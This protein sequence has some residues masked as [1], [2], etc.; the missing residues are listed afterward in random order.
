LPILANP[1]PF[2]LEF[3]RKQKA[4]SVEHPLEEIQHKNEAKKG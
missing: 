2:L 4:L 1:L 3:H